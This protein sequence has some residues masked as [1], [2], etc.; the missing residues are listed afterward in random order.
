VVDT[1]GKRPVN[2][3]GGLLIKKIKKIKI[4]GMFTRFDLKKN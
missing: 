4:P 2:G 1:A 3:C